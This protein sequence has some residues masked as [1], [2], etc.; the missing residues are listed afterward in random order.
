MILPLS[1]IIPSLLHARSL[2]RSHPIH[3]ILLVYFFCCFLLISSSVAANFVY[4]A[5]ITFLDHLVSFF[6]AREIGVDNALHRHF[7]WRNNNFDPKLLPPDS[8]VVLSELDAFVPSAAVRRHLNA[9]R[10]DCLVEMLEGHFHA[11]FQVVPSS[12]KR[13]E[14]LSQRVDNTR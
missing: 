11:Q 4:R 5:P 12:F 1:M 13:V 10:P 14:M 3:F 8:A 7:Q 2:A 6:V 9:E